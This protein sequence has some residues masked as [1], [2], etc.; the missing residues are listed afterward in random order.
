MSLSNEKI[1]DKIQKLTP[2]QCK[3][4]N[5]KIAPDLASMDNDQNTK[6]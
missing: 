3:N 2:L 1:S 6:F 4:V 5:L